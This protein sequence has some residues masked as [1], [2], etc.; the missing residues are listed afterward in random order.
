MKTRVPLVLLTLAA[1]VVAAVVLTRVLSADGPA[2]AGPASEAARTSLPGLTPATGEPTLASLGGLRPRPGTVAQAAG[3]FDDRFAFQELTFSK[4]R[5]RGSVQVSSDVSELLE[6][7][8]LAGF[9]DESGRLLGTARHVDHRT[10]GSGAAHA[11]EGPP[12]ARFD[13]A[14]PKG[15]RGATVSAAVGVVVLVNE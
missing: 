2:P 15:L 9:Y 1:A 11:D 10:E 4:A 3:P 7:E 12:S 14:V 8:V 6:L 5:V 13:I